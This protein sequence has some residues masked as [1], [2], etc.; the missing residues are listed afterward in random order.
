MEHAFT[1]PLCGAM[2][3]M[4]LDCGGHNVTYIED[5]KV[6]CNPLGIT[7]TTEDDILMHFEVRTLE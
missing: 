2:I 6:C 7:Y 4:V 3:S 1:C 5:C